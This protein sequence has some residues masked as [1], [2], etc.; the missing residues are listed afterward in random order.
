MKFNMKFAL[1]AFILTIA[2]SS[3]HAA[4]INCYQFWAA[5]SG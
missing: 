4:V 3:A 2:T 1:I 5:K